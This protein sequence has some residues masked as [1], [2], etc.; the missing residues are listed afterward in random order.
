LFSKP[1]AAVDAVTSVAHALDS[2]IQ[3]SVD[4]LSA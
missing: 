1:D 4:S 3:Q 2:A